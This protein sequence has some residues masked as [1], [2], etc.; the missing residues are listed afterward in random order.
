MDCLKPRRGKRQDPGKAI[1]ISFAKGPIMMNIC[2]ST[3]G[4][5]VSAMVMVEPFGK[6]N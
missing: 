6:K 2:R 5:T 4:E 1:R 3:L